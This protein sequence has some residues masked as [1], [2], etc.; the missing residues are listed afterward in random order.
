MRSIHE[1]FICWQTITAVFAFLN[2]PD[3]HSALGLGA[4]IRDGVVDYSGDC[5]LV[6][7]YVASVLGF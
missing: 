4:A 6:C 7:D 3:R 5:R 1:S 2:S